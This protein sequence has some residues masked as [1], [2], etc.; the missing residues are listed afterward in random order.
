MLVIV[1]EF[2][3]EFRLGRHRHNQTIPRN[4]STDLIVYLSIV[5][6]FL[7]LS[8]STLHQDQIV[9]LGLSYRFVLGRVGQHSNF[10]FLLVV[11]YRIFSTGS[12]QGFYGFLFSSLLSNQPTKKSYKRDRNINFI[13]LLLDGK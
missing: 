13:F 9:G 2:V 7:S 5:S 3:G 6:L 12:Y 11:L 8:I 10:L 1:P 4:Q